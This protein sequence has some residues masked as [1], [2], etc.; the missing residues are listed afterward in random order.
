ML[1]QFSTENLVFND[2]NKINQTVKKLNV[3][4]KLEEFNQSSVLQKMKRCI[5][6]T[7]PILLAP[8][9]IN[10]IEINYHSLTLTGT[11]P[12]QTLAEEK[13]ISERASI[14]IATPLNTHTRMSWLDVIEFLEK[15]DG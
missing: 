3:A 1:K 14:N 2:R 10:I 13:K 15:M 8:T 5:T 11:K 6:C 12:F 7:Q 4:R 9:H